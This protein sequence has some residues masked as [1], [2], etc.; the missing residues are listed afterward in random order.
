MKISAEDVKFVRKWAEEKPN[1][2]LVYNRQCDWYE[3]IEGADFDESIHNKIFD[4]YDT[5]VR[6]D[7]LGGENYDFDLVEKFMIDMA[8]ARLIDDMVA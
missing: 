5:L 3:R 8:F 6:F 4:P 2:M 7:L 1:L